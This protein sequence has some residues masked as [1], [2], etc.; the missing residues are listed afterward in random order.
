[1]LKCQSDL[2]GWILVHMC[3]VFQ[4]KVVS[5]ENSTKEHNNYTDSTVG[6]A[7]HN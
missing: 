5:F 7:F 6:E 1:M 4:V 2:S 3:D